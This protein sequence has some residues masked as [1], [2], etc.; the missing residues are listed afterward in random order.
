M[1]TR[2]RVGRPPRPTS[3]HASPPPSQRQAWLKTTVGA[4]P[5]LLLFV[6]SVTACCVHCCNLLH[7]AR[8][9]HDFVWWCRNPDNEQGVWCYTTDGP[10]WER[11][12]VPFCDPVTPPTPPPSGGSLSNGARNGIIAGVPF[13]C[14]S[15]FH[16][17]PFFYALH[18]LAT[19]ACSIATTV[20]INSRYR[21]VCSRGASC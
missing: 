12:S 6:V 16:Q 2:V 11:C 17:L 3:T 20:N 9:Q 10:R 19:A 1:G 5:N 4:T 18:L 13:P 8:D 14:P 21:T 15:L 7:H